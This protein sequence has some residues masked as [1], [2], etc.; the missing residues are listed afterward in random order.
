MTRLLLGQAVCDGEDG[1]SIL[2]Q[3]SEL[4]Y[5]RSVRRHKV[6]HCVELLDTKGCLFQVRIDALSKESASL[7]VLEQLDEIAPS[8]P[9]HIL[10]APP[11]GKILDDIVRKMNEIGVARFTPLRCER[12]VMIPGDNRV[13]RWNRIAIESVR[14]CRRSQPLVVESPVS[15]L[16][17]LKIP[18]HCRFILHPGN[19]G[20]RAGDL[21][22]QQQFDSIAVLI[23]P[24]GGFSP[25]EVE[26]AMEQKCRP[27]QLGK[28]ILR[29]ETAIMVASVVAVSAVGGFDK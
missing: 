6:G 26:M 22:K 1:K 14:Q 29:I 27:L 23:G 28:S 24:E 3:G 7:M 5:L 9:V 16:E 15:F 21:F 19:K 2:L 18:A 8:V 12:S 25:A 17:A 10:A 11:K 20:I 4:H 13:E